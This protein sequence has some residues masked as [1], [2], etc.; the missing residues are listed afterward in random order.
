MTLYIYAIAQAGDPGPPD[1]AI[2]IPAGIG[3][4]PVY[5]IDS[6]SLGAFVSECQGTTIRAERRHISASQGVLRALQAR[7]D[8]LPMA[9]GTL[10]DSADTVM[11]LLDRHR[12]TLL[13]QLQRIAG[14]VEMGV[15]L[16]LD[17]PD[18]IAYL[19]AHTPELRQARDRTFSRRKLPSHEDRI[20]L[21][22]M[23][24]SALR[25]YQ[26]T[27]VAELVTLLSPACKAISTLPIQGDR[28]V[29]NLAVLVP[30]AGLGEFEAA[31]NAAAERFEDDL[32][33][34][35]NGPWPPHN[36]VKLELDSH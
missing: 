4:Q 9:F 34:N 8:L 25:R 19:V 24:E 29:A 26:E 17:V 14:S 15:R 31:V 28:Q 6:G 22:Q 2:D 13:A 30:R 23:C 12:E 1:P 20:R 7:L 35:L 3:G 36:F 18:P 10:T 27:K 16:N 21:G 32:A 33:F 5:R 11:A